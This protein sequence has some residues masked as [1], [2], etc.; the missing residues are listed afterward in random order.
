MEIIRK[1]SAFGININFFFCLT[2]FVVLCAISQKSVYANELDY[3]LTK[4]LIVVPEQIN[5][6]ENAGIDMFLDE[7][8]KRTDIKYSVVNEIPAPSVPIIVIGTYE[9]LSSNSSFDSYTKKYQ[10]NSPEGYSILDF[11]EFREAPSI[12]I[13]GNDSRGMLFGIGYFLRKILMIPPKGISTPE[14]FPSGWQKQRTYSMIQGS[15][16]TPKDIFVENNF[17]AVSLRGHQLG[18]RP[19]VNAYDGFDEEMYEQYIRDLI[20]FGTN[21]VELM[22][23]NTDDASYSPMFQIPQMEMNDKISR[24]LGRYGLDVWLW[25][26]LMYGD[27]TKQDNFQNSMEEAEEV[28][29]SMHK[30]NAV[31]VP[32]GDPG[33]TPP[34]VLFNYLEKEKQILNKYHPDAEIWVSPQGFSVEWFDEFIELVSQEPEWL[35]G[36]VHGPWVRMNVDNLRKI[37][38]DK[39]QIRRYPDITHSFRCEYPVPNWDLAFASTQHREVINPRPVDQS[40]IFKSMNLNRSCGFITYS[41]GVNDDVN[42]MIWSGLGWNPDTKVDE[43]LQDYSRYFIGPDYANDFAK[44]L[45]G[46]EQNWNG[47]LLDNQLVY[48]NLLKFQQ[49]EK[50]AMPKVRLNWRFQQALY[51]SYYDAYVRSRLLYETHLEDAALSVLRRA[52]EIGSITAMGHASKILDKAK[53]EKVADDWR[54]RVFELGEALFQSIRMQLSVEKYHAISVGRGANLDLIDQPINN[55]GWLIAN[56]ERIAEL[57]TESERL[58]EIDNIINWRNPGTGGY[59]I[60]FGDL[61]ENP[62]L[63]HGADYK[64]DPGFW[65]SPLIGYRTGS[66]QIMGWR[67]SWKRFIHTLFN[68]PLE[69][70]FENLESNANYQL[71]IVYLRGPV[72]LTADDDIIIHDY[73]KMTPW[74]IEIRTFD[75][76]VDATRNGK[77]TLKWEMEPARGSH[78]RGNLIAEMWLMKK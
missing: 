6:V 55:S 21:A 5:E 45:F 38:P 74:D 27:Y 78:G 69:M 30:I 24:I 54:Q 25:Y 37:I 18:Y 34:K 71:K 53:I 52:P 13:I 62:F 41:E 19:K 35:T 70:Q 42:K 40:T 11:T 63:V 73:F 10:W 49:M 26:P 61:S 36:I 32:G 2:S 67:N 1:N 76:P 60:D 77:L 23:P 22:P 43:I 44:G 31:F 46:L 12:L 47:S 48:V 8:Q 28:F 56:F 3:D 65:H 50:N 64:N 59:Y 58:N 72:K 9:S 20:I 66:Q 29:K 14:K 39:Y 68:H 16:K 75:I 57:D 17:P 51:R 15:V 4:A 7:V 33:H